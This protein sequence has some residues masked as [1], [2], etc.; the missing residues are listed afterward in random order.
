MTEKSIFWTTLTTGDGADAYP[1][2]EVIAAIEALVSRQAARNGVFPIDNKLAIVG[3]NHAVTPQVTIDT[4][5]AVVKGFI[6]RNDALLTKNLVLPVVGTTGWRVVIQA[7]GGTTR[8]IRIAVLQSADGTAD[9]PAATQNSG[10]P[11]SGVWEIS[12]A[13][14]T[15]TTGG[16]VAVTDH[17]SFCQFL[18]TDRQG[19]SATGWRD[20][21]DTNYHLSDVAQIQVGVKNL[22]VLATADGGSASVVFPASFGYTPVIFAMVQATAVGGYHLTQVVVDIT[23]TDGF[24]ILGL[25]DAVDPAA[26][27]DYSISW[28]AIGPRA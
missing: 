15:V 28:I 19:G 21:G 17:R 26:D 16:V 9:I 18:V 23:D 8:T 20:V 4:G 2:D 1:Q 3:I 11:A 27:H 22:R 24:L 7:T 5:R 25:Q 6:Y 12:I 10:F 14:G 13:Y